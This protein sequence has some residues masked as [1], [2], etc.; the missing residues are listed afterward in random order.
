VVNQTLADIG[1]ADKKVLMVFNKIDAY[2]FIAKDE[3]D[4]TP[5]TRENISLEELQGSWIAKE[6]IDSVFVSAAKGINIAQL[7]EKLTAMVRKRHQVLYPQN[8][9]SDA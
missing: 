5:S 3:D 7:R 4:L 6:N 1:A 2:R 9:N 8:K